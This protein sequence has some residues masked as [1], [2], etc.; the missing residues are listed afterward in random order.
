MTDKQT[1]TPLKKVRIKRDRQTD[2]PLKKMRTSRRL[3][4]IRGSYLEL[5]QDKV[6]IIC[7][8]Q[9]IGIIFAVV[10]INTFI[11]I[12]ISQT[13]SLIVPIHFVEEGS[14]HQQWNLQLAA[15]RKGRVVGQSLN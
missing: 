7:D 9:L 8:R 12:V 3:D 2:I 10:I 14:N 11:L 15:K 13:I 6:I 5:H 1:D 4:A